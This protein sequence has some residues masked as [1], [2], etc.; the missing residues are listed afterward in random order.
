VRG[1]DL[2]RSGDVKDLATIDRVAII[3]YKKQ[4]RGF[5]AAGDNSCYPIEAVPREEHFSEKTKIYQARIS[6]M[7]ARLRQ[8]REPAQPFPSLELVVDEPHVDMEEDPVDIEEDPFETEIPGVYS[9]SEAGERKLV[10]L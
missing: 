4:I 9:D 2:G 1:S 7:E 3:G 5:N 10:L 6:V 8:S